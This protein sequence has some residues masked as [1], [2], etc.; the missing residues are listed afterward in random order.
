M[1]WP[2]QASEHDAD[3][4]EP[5]EGGDGAR[6]SLEITRQAAIAAN[7]G[8]GSFDDPALGQDDEL[9]QFVALDDLEHPT[10]GAGSGL[11]G[12]WSLIAGIGEDPLDEGEEAARAP[13]ENQPRPVAVLN[14]AGMDDDVQQKTKRIDEDVTLAS[15]DLLARIVAL[16]VERGAPFM[17]WPAPLLHHVRVGEWRVRQWTLI[18]SGST[19]A[20]IAAA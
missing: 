19:W 9:V 4:G 8:Q 18:F 17:E 15:S 11:R 20:R 1:T 2:C 10:A 5:D 16:R 13:I 6:I 3:H 14:I 12:A 7:P